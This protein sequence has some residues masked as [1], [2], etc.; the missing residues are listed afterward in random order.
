[1]YEIKENSRNRYLRK[2][3]F[4]GSGHFGELLVC[5]FGEYACNFY[6]CGRKRYSI[7]IAACF[8]FRGC[9]VFYT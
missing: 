6:T 8:A 4:F 3:H 1:M 9:L 7:L 2:G 5:T